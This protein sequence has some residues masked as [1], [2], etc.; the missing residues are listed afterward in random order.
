MH[1][2]KDKLTALLHSEHSTKVIVILGAAGMMLIL[3][4][5]FFPK[6][7]TAKQEQIISAATAA[8]EPDLYRQQLE[9]RLTELLSQM[10]G[11]GAVTVMVTVGGSS[12]QIYA[13]EIKSSRSTNSSMN[14]SAPVL[15]RSGSTEAPLIAETRYPEVCGAAILCTGGGHAVIQERIKQAASALL[16]IPP[17]KIY[18]GR[19]NTATN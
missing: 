10:E 18:V 6:K 11:V 19:S 17:A 14:E 3:F 12:E 13:E 16:G 7:Q 15:T 2:L 8:A 9:E 5:G 4:S 1:E